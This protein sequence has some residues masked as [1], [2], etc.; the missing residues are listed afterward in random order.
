MRILA[1]LGLALLAVLPD[2]PAMAQEK[3]PSQ[4]IRL[5]SGFA[6]GGVTDSIARFLAE[7]IRAKYGQQ[8]TVENRPGAS[9][10]LATVDL[11]RATPDGYAL[12]VG[13]FGGQLIPPLIIP[14]YPVDVT[15]D[16]THLAGIAEFM[17]VMTVSSRLPV[18]NVQE[19]IKH[20]KENPGKLTFGSAGV[21]SSNYLS[22]VLFMQ[23]TGVEMTHVP[24]R[25]GVGPITDLL[26]GNL[27]VVFE[28]VPI[29]MGQATS[30][31]LRR[32]AVTGR[33]RSPQFPE[34][35]TMTESGVP[36]YVITSW[37]GIY[38]PPNMPPDLVRT[39]SDVIVTAASDPAVQERMRQIGFQPLGLRA[40]EFE[41]FFQAERARWKQVVDAA[42]IRLQTQ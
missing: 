1:A 18:T 39:V 31:R 34:T 11:T 23:K 6:A 32:L 8:V 20:A 13:G 35:P 19:F 7:S 4:P 33:E 26:A 12:M 27:D 9:G 14:N 2:R 29:M 30:D 16:I 5:V 24:Y 17:N 28:N 40:A 37:I 38:G 15:R 42:G 36:D 25:G 10:S 21:G 3:Y 41:A 22:A